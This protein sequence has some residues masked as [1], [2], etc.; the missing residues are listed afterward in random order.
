MVMSG[1][2]D[3]K[4][5]TGEALKETKPAAECLRCLLSHY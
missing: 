1:G 5:Q 3:L 2:L 4:G